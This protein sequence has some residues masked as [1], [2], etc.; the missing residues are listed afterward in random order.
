VAIIVICET[1]QV[2]EWRLTESGNLSFYL[3][4]PSKNSLTFQTKDSPR[5]WSRLCGWRYI[6]CFLFSRWHGGL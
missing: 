4:E 1:C 5:Q 3:A 2:A 6:V